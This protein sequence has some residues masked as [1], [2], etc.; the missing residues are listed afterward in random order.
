MRKKYIIFYCSADGKFRDHCIISGVSFA[1]AY[2]SAGTF[3]K[4][5]GLNILGIVEEKVLKGNYQIY[6]Y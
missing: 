1:D 2:K 6:K 3:R 5:S 4:I